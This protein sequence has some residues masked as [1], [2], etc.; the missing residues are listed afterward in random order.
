LALAG[1]SGASVILFSDCWITDR[2]IF[3]IAGHAGLP[4]GHMTIVNLNLVGEILCLI[5]EILNL[6]K[7]QFRSHAK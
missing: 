5:A 3:F 4:E 2:N 7:M 6:E 1:F